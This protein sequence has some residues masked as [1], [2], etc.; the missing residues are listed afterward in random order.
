MATENS[1]T[2]AK[3]NQFDR[4]RWNFPAKFIVWLDPNIYH[5]DPEYNYLTKQLDT[6]VNNVTLFQHMDE[7][8]QYLQVLYEEKIIV[9]TFWGTRRTT[10]AAD[11]FAVNRVAVVYIFCAHPSRHSSWTSAWSK[12]KGIFDCVEL[13]V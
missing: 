10:R 7:C 3:R 2:E 1:T 6:I 5:H 4:I 13:I 11:S 9:I 12:I 8:I